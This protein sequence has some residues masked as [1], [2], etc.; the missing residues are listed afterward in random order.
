MKDKGG[1]GNQQENPQDG[2]ASLTPIKEREEKR[3]LGRKTLTL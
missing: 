1:S 2:H 3:G